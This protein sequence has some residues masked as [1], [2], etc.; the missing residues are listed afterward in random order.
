MRALRDAGMLAGAPRSRFVVAKDGQAAAARWGT[1][2]SALRLAGSDDPALDLLIREAGGSVSVAPGPRGSVHG[3]VGLARGTADAAAVHLL[4]AARGSWNDHLVRGALAGEPVRLVHLWRREQGLVLPPGN[5]KG[6]RGIRDLEG[7]RVAYRRP[8]TGSRLLLEH[9]ML[10]HGCDPRPE[11]GVVTDSHLGVAAAVA[12]G[13]AEVGL[14]VRAVAESAGLEWVHV[15]S[16]PFELAIAVGSEPTAEPLL[17][18]LA[19]P[20]LQRRLAAMPG[21]DLS[22]S[23]DRRNP[24]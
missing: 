14:A 23:G 17:D 5:P 15:T 21:Y 7:R 6:V 16:E 3:L 24:A 1:G 18:C 2:V 19:R 10:S 9:L 13:A 11:L 22:V 20:S 8:G 12:S 4:D